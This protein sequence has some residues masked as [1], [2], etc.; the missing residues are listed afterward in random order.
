[1]TEAP[2]PPERI[3]HKWDQRLEKYGLLEGF[4]DYLSDHGITFRIGQDERGYDCMI[5]EMENVNYDERWGGKLEDPMSKYMGHKVD[6]D[7]G[8]GIAKFEVPSRYVWAGFSEAID[9]LQVRQDPKTGEQRISQG[10]E[11]H[12][13]LFFFHIMNVDR[14]EKVMRYAFRTDYTDGDLARRRANRRK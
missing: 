10:P 6:I 12:S 3:P 14:P 13:G 1:M 5:V 4:D 9:T 8:A 7:E 2:K 11:T